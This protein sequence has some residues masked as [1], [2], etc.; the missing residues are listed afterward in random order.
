ME[1]DEVLLPLL[2]SRNSPVQ[3]PLQTFRRQRATQGGTSFSTLVGALKTQ[4]LGGGNSVGRKIGGEGSLVAGPIPNR[5]ASGQNSG[6]NDRIL[7]STQ[8]T[9]VATTAPVTAAAKPADVALTGNISVD[10]ISLLSAK[11]RERGFDPANYGMRYSEEAVY[12]PGGSYTNR[13]I[14][15]NVNGR[16]ESFDAGLV[17]RNPEVAAIEM[18][19][20]TGQLSF[21]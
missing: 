10:A 14:T 15:A 9:S 17:M 13:Q 12:Y 6:G 8:K 1:W 21:S 11:L 7:T 5:P 20:A 18:L 16:T 19:R 2:V 4:G 3:F